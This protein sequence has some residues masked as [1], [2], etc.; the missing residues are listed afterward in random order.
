VRYFLPL[1]GYLMAGCAV[2]TVKSSF[3]GYFWGY[4]NFL[5]SKKLAFMRFADNDLQDVRSAKN[6][7]LLLFLSQQA[8]FLMFFSCLITVWVT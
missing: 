8:F 6:K 4:A 3:R 5:N 2:I 7:G 1:G